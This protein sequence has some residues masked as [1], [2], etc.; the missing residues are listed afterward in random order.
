MPDQLTVGGEGLGDALVV[1]LPQHGDPVGDLEA[2]VLAGLLQRPHDVPGGTEQEQLVV[3]VKVEGQRL[4]AAAGDGPPF[5][6]H[7]G[8]DH[9]VGREAQSLTLYLNLTLPAPDLRGEFGGLCR[10]DGGGHCR[11]ALAE[12]LPERAEVGFHGHVDQRLGVG[13]RLQGQHVELV[14]DLLPGLV[15][16][17]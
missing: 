16:E 7:L 12:A 14:G 5:L 13:Q 3:E 6:W 9:L 15:I 11:G 1:G 8:D 4:T 17:V 2:G 10:P